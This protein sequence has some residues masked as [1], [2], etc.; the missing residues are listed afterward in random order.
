MK[1]SPYLTYYRY[2]FIHYFCFTLTFIDFSLGAVYMEEGSY[3]EAKFMLEQSMELLQ[4]TTT[5]LELTIKDRNNYSIDT[6]FFRIKACK[7]KL[8][9][10]LAL[11]A[12]LEHKSGNLEVAKRLYMQYLNTSKEMDNVNG[13]AESLLQLAGIYKEEKNYSE[14]KNL[15]SMALQVAYGVQA[16]DKVIL[17]TFATG[18]LYYLTGDFE[19][20]RSYFSDCLQQTQANC[21]MRMAI[22]VQLAWAKLEIENSM[23]ENATKL[24]KRTLGAAVEAKDEACIEKIKRYLALLEDRELNVK[25]IDW[26]SEDSSTD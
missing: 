10:A 21:D 3:T 6:Q 11:F 12:K 15:Y 1:Y 22:K 2:S 9:A 26:S 18:E 8:T 19:K 5:T 24:L 4:S 25:K 16:V 7:W 17:I 20:A 23:F 13:I 14:A